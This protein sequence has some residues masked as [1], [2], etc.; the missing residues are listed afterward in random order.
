M[1]IGLFRC[2]VCSSTL[3]VPI[4]LSC[5][6][7]ICLPCLPSTV[8]ATENKSFIC[9]VPSCVKD[10]HLFG[11]SL[12]E[13]ET[14]KLCL[15]Q[16]SDKISSAE[17]YRTISNALMCSSSSG[18]HLLKS[19]VTNH[20]GHAFCR[21]CLLWQK[22]TT[23]S[24]PKCQKRLPSYQFIQHQPVT[25]TIDGILQSLY[26]AE[27]STVD[28][29]DIPSE[30]DIQTISLSDPN[31]RYSHIPIIIFD[32]PILPSQKI[33]IPIYT[34]YNRAMIHAAVFICKELQ[35]LC[36]AISYKPKSTHTG[37]YGILAKITG[38][39]NKSDDILIDIIGLDRFVAR[40]IHKAAE[41]HLIADIE[42]KLETINPKETKV[43]N[44]SSSTTELANRVH[45]FITDLSCSHPSYSFCNAVQGLL[46]PVWLQSVQNIHGPLPSPNDPIS[47]CWW[48]AIILP[49][50]NQDRYRLLEI[51]SLMDRLTLIVSWI[52][53]LETQWDR[54]TK[55]DM[56]SVTRA[57]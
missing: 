41:D 28:T 1:T 30:S 36:L 45:A 23:N 26:R 27:Q 48:A 52:H 20:C 11:P 12:H 46:G 6:Y 37:H 51:D 18:S 9:P 44:R 25:C 47:F 8:R 33:R 24:C 7:T 19:P 5:G 17:A 3:T 34:L 35:C 43:P 22:I 10:K 15:S 4:T 57:L 13:D 42:L 38:V 56:T 50:A 40:Q 55:K 16:R 21:L 31:R 54:Y 29:L 14:I 2:S 49:V 32:F 53:D 39:E